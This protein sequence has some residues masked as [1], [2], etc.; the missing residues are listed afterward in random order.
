M[1]CVK[2][3][4]VRPIGQADVFNMEVEEYHNFSIEGGLIVHNCGYMLIS[5]HAGKSKTITN[6]TKTRQQKHKENVM[7]KKA[8]FARRR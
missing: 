6:E 5:H 1:N 2:V 4:S 3:E 7:H 8:R